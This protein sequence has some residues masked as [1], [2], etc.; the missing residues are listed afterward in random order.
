[1]MKSVLMGNRIPGRTNGVF[2]E[3]SEYTGSSFEKT[4]SCQIQEVFVCTLQ[5]TPMEVLW[6][7]HLSVD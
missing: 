1:M 3:Q 5:I 4:T 6:K 2:Q 7:L